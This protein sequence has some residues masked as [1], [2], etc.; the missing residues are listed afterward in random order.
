[1]SPVTYKSFNYGL[2]EITHLSAADS[3][4]GEAMVRLGM[5]METKEVIKCPK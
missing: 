1:M 5:P 4:L 2:K 3:V